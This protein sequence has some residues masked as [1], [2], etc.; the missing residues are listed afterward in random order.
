M[1]DQFGFKLRLL[2]DKAG[3]STQALLEILTRIAKNEMEARNIGRSSAPRANKKKIEL[4]AA[5]ARAKNW[6]YDRGR[7]GIN[8]AVAAA[9]EI[10][11]SDNTYQSSIK[12]LMLLDEASFCK[13]IGV[14]HFIAARKKGA[15]IPGID[16]FIQEKRELYMF[17]GVYALC[18]WDIKESKKLRICPMTIFDGGENIQYKYRTPDTEY[19]G[20]VLSIG[21]NMVF[22]GETSHRA[23]FEVEMLI[24]EKNFTPAKDC[25]GIATGVDGGTKPIAHKCV[26]VRLTQDT[27]GKVEERWNA[28]VPYFLGQ[29]M[30]SGVYGRPLV[31]ESTGGQMYKNIKKVLTTLKSDSAGIRVGQ[32][33]SPSLVSD[34]VTHY[35]AINSGITIEVMMGEFRE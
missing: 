1:P 23:Q 20:F 21:N 24:L 9:K 12:K 25:L 11:Y 13:E 30:P 4:T 6:L 27:G 28:L 29:E 14:R 16:S 17:L 31:D 26:A 7:I 32:T 3:V 2:A 10:N 34:I 19:S 22:I 8:N 15:P 33:I 5:S 18:Y 35:A